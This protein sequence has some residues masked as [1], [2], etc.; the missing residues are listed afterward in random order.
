MGN[1]EWAEHP[2]CFFKKPKTPKEL[3]AFG[4][5]QGPSAK[6]YLQEDVI[7][8]QSVEKPLLAR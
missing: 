2:G 3:V 7:T 5:E 1:G 4:V 6:N 8:R